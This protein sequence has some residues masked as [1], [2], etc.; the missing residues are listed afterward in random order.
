MTY[1]GCPIFIR[2]SPPLS[3]VNML[4]I[5][6]NYFNYLFYLSFES[7]LSLLFRNKICLIFL[8]LL[9]WRRLGSFIVHCHC[10][11]VLP[12]CQG[13]ER[14]FLLLLYRPI[15]TLAVCRI[16]SKF[17]ILHSAMPCVGFEILYLSTANVSVQFYPLKFFR[18]LVVH[19]I[20]F[21]CS[22]TRHSSK[23]TSFYFIFVFYSGGY[24]HAMMTDRLFVIYQSVTSYQV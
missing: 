13:L 6:Q 11:E 10:Y 9:R 3:S 19:Y 17:F 21:K 8:L 7:I 4:W 15:N 14:D 16:I 20:I 12:I 5:L 24:L 2:Q 23:F 1:N 18:P 22:V